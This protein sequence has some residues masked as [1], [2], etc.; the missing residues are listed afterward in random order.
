[1]VAGLQCPLQ[2]LLQWLTEHIDGSLEKETGNKD[3]FT[4][5]IP[6]YTVG[7]KSSVE[8]G[9]SNFDRAIL[10]AQKAIKPA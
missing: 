1:M 5:M 10:K 9:K 6:L 2:H 8:L 3:N 4:E 7:N